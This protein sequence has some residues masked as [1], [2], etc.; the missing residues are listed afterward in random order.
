[1][2]SSSEVRARLESWWIV[3]KCLECGDWFDDTSSLLGHIKSEH[4]DIWKNLAENQ[5]IALVFSR[6]LGS[7]GGEK[8]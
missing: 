2:R 7:G 4:P 1:M 6:K 5:H 8:Q 3:L